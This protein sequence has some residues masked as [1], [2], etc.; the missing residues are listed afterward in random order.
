VSMGVGMRVRLGMLALDRMRVWMLVL[1][2]MGVGMRV[3]MGM[4][5][6]ALH[7][8]S[9]LRCRDEDTDFLVS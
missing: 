6:V 2:S 8:R 4:L 7:G 5:V 3:R 1:V 9:P